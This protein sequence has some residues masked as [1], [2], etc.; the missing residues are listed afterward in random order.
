MSY[1]Q[2]Y[3]GEDFTRP[4]LYILVG[5]QLKEVGDLAMVV[6]ACSRFNVEVEEIVNIFLGQSSLL[7]D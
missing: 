2:T 1:S 3:R 6:A 7:E 4:P 5:A